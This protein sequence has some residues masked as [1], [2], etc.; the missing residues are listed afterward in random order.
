M[1]DNL[2]LQQKEFIFQYVSKFRNRVAFYGGFYCY[3]NEDSPLWNYL[4]LGFFCLN[5]KQKAYD[6][7]LALVKSEILQFSSSKLVTNK[8]FYLSERHF[9]W[10]IFP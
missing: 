4:L 3:W 10:L 7:M 8:S 2:L 5:V 6:L 1:L 9:L